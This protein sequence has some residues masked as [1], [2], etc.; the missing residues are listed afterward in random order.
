VPQRF[1]RKQEPQ[2]TPWSLPDGGWP[3]AM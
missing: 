2:G 1:F 3:P